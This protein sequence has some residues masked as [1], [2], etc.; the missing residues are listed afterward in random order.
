MAIFD[1]ETQELLRNIKSDFVQAYGPDTKTKDIPFHITLGSY[2]VE[3]TDE[4][5]ARIIRIAGQ[6][7]RFAVKFKGLN[8]FGHSVRFLEPEMSS[9]LMDLHKHFDSDYANGYNG[10]MPHATLYRHS[11]PK[12]IELPG[13]I[14]GKL[15][16][17]TNPTII[18]IELG[19]FFPPKQ[20]IRVLFDHQ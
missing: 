17:L 5:T 10:W 14:K 1:D 2:A 3:E 19:E 8:H 12:E 20:I 7:E 6:T 18:G 4:I 9:H 15:D 11:E 13:Q 16:K